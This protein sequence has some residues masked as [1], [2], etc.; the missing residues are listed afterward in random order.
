MKLN[1]GDIYFGAIVDEH[2]SERKIIHPQVIIQDTVINN[3]RIDTVVVCEISSNMKK[4]S[5]PGNI[6]LQIGEGNLE[7]QSIIIPAHISVIK[8]N[9]LKN[10]VGRLGK[11]RIDQI[12]HGLKM[13][14]GFRH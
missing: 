14:E 5:E 10:Y 6:L 13:L 12:F 7:R 3:S 4:V 8:K 1:Q 11:E 2:G 9:R